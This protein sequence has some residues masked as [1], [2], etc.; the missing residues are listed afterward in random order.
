MTEISIVTNAL[1]KSSGGPT[2]TIGAFQQAL[3]AGVVNFASANDLAGD[4]LAL[5]DVS[6]IETTGLPVL[7]Q[8]CVRKLKK[9]E[10][11]RRIETDLATSSLISCHL[12]YRYHALW[13]NK[14]SRK[15]GV[16]YW[17][18]PHGV[19]DPWVMTYGRAVKTLYLK[20]GGQR[21]LDE[22]ATVIF[23]TSAER[24]KASVQFELPRSEVIPWPV[25]LV[26]VEDRQASREQVR[27]QL[28]IPESARVLLYFGRIHS[29]KRPME[30]IKALSLSRL[31]N[32]HLII[33]GNENNVA[34]EDCRRAAI[35][36]GLEDQVHLVGPV[37]GQSK[38]DYLHASDAYISLSWRENFN[39]T[40]AESLAAGLPVILSPGNDLQSDIA[41]ERCSWGL[42]DNE[43]KT[44][45]KKIEEFA[46]T[47]DVDLRQMG[48]RGRSWVET[49]LNFPLFS[50]RLNDA[51]KRYSNA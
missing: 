44:A 11:F 29:M 28:N 1:K 2:K 47:S 32:I 21:F 42:A 19:L 9:T 34:L 6:V 46:A 30:T 35:D 51:A 20:F 45:A 4:G 7:K 26:G 48:D 12:F 43:L 39:H 17:F 33:V 25:D 22:A 41:T 8:F 38:F 5:S 40:A 3:S 24:D 49:N 23:S 16:P 10:D 37:Y 31:K 50:K 13:V 27:H 15:Y 18:V 36:L 14:L